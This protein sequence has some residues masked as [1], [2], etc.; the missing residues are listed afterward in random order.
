M[1][2]SCK[3]LRN[4]VFQHTMVFSVPKGVVNVLESSKKICSTYDI[5]KF[6]APFVATLRYDTMAVVTILH[7]LR[8]ARAV[9]LVQLS[10]LQ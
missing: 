9:R 2:K 10:R 7:G 1:C 6:Q 3:N 4:G 5:T 8:I